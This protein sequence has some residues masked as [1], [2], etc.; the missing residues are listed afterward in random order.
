MAADP[1]LPDIGKFLIGHL[2]NDWKESHTHWVWLFTL[3]QC[4]ALN[5]AYRLEACFGNIIC[6]PP[7]SPG[8]GFIQIE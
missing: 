7:Q 6:S 8:Q 2:L 5:Q 4:P 3:V 1:K